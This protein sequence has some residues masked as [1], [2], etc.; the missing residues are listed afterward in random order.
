MT[1]NTTAVC[2]TEGSF[3]YEGAFNYT[4]IRNRGLDIVGAIYM[5]YGSV[6]IAAQGL[7]RWAATV[8]MKLMATE[9]PQAIRTLV[10]IPDKL[11]VLPDPGQMTEERLRY[12]E[13]TCFTKVEV[14][15]LTGKA[16][17]LYKAG[18]DDEALCAVFSTKKG[19]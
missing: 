17:R 8:L 3:I 18:K 14:V 13:E 7:M 9:S 15:P 12:F 11:S 1:K 10:V 4:D 19:A 2:Y 6:E 16:L 5:E